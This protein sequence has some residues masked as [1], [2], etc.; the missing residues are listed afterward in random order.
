MMEGWQMARRQ[1][2]DPEELF[3][4]ANRLQAEGKE[5]TA[6]ALLDAL[7]G[8]SLRTIYKYLD[9]WK[10][11]R[12]A[13]PVARSGEIPDR[14]QAGFAVAWRLATDEAALAIEAAKE[15][16]AEEV[17]AANGQ[18]EE[19]LDP[20]EKLEKEAEE[21]TEQ[22]EALKAQVMQQAQEISQLTSSKASYKATAEQLQQ[23][24]RS[25]EQELERTH[26]GQ[27]EEREKHTAQVLRLEQS[28][29]LVKEKF[30]KENSDLKA[31]L[32]DAR[33][34]LALLEREKEEVKS[35]SEESRKQLEKAAAA[36]ES[37]RKERDAAIKEASELKGKSETLKTQNE[38][39]LAKLT[40]K[41]EKEE[42]KK[43]KE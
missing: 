25:L 32:A 37:D 6:T 26:K 3:E 21:A 41:T 19:A 24:V 4:T 5:V 20:V 29:A 39:L 12:P 14:V 2:I 43:G 27:A 22:I 33:S 31:A 35:A 15:K 23:Q 42:K 10:D 30:E 8:G 11:K 34:K 40:E 18:F 1:A 7:G 28:T 9:M 13:A 38:Q 16:A 36:A 17:A